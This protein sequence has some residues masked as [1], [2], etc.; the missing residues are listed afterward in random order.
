MITPGEIKMHDMF[1]VDL[2]GQDANVAKI[3]QQYPHAQVT[4][5]FHSMLATVV[6]CVNK[7]RTSHVWIVASCSDCAEFDFDWYP[8]PW[9]ANQIHCWAAGIQK[10]G[11]VLLV[12]AGE[13]VKQSPELLEW[14]ADVNYHVPGPNRLAWPRV[15]VGN[16]DLTTVITQTEFESE[17][18]LFDCNV[19]TI[20]IDTEPSLWGENPHQLISFS[21]DNSISLVPKTAQSHLK[22]QVYDYQHLV[23]AN[24]VPSTLQDIVFISYDEPQADEN[25]ARLVAR[26]PHARRVH[27]VEGMEN[28]LKAAAHASST[29]WFYAT[30]AKTRLHET[31]DFSFVPDRWQAPKQ[32]IFNAL[33]ASNGLCYGHMG[34]IMYHKESVLNSK[35]WAEIGGMDFTM[36]FATE[37]IPLTSVYGEFA[38][39]PYH[40]WRTAFREV[41]KLC[42]WQLDKPS[43]ETDYRINVWRTHATG[44]NAEWVLRGAQDGAEFFTNNSNNNQELKKAFRW[45]WLKDFYQSKYALDQ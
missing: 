8:V 23:R 37:S 28:A 41:S 21:K 25:W 18:V 32:Y 27:G 43:V 42:Q 29:P 6:R 33:N 34:I 31:W 13:F 5:Y 10:F 11:D 20:H 39:T 2:G 36:S 3:Q 24:S 19:S 35:P 15:Y 40:A 12:P 22:T 1:I 9:E 45:E 7:S 44:P 16:Q 14:F 30:F 4:R 17:Y 38:I 26:F